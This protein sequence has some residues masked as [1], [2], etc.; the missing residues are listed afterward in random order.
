[1]FKV[2]VEYADGK[3]KV[4]TEGDYNLLGMHCVNKGTTEGSVAEVVDK[5][6]DYLVK[7]IEVQKIF[8]GDSDLEP[9]DAFVKIG[10][11]IG[12]KKEQVVKLMNAFGCEEEEEK[13]DPS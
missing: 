3:V 2:I 13:K 8:N 4:E 1:M 6:I 9:T 7:M 5:Y 12:I 11:M 10:D